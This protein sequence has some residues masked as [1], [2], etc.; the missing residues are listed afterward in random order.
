[1][2]RVVNFAHGEFAVLAMYAAWMAHTQWQLDPILAALPI[3][4]G[5]FALGYGL[6][7]GLVSPFVG[8]AEHEQ[9]IL[10]AGVA[11]VLVNL[12]LMGFGPDAR[13]V[14][15]PYALD[16]YAIGPV[17]LD[18]ARLYVAGVALAMLVTVSD[19][20][21]VLAHGFT[22]QGFIIVIIGGLGSL[23]GALLGGVLIGVCEALAGFLW[24]PSMKSLFSFLLLVAVLA[25]RPQGLLGKQ[26]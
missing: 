5:C 22:L 18:K 17:T 6:K 23:G 9:F 26:P 7:R 4:A 13:P 3:A 20:L 11:M 14:N 24:Q 12:L 15:L 1:V 8:R 10:L 25:L 21:P 19:A 2:I 16:S